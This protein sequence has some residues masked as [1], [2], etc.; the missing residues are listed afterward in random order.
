MAEERY[1]KFF[2]ELETYERSGVSMRLNDHPASPMQIVTAHMVRED[3]S[4]M[5]DYVW[6]EKG[7]V[8]EL[9]FHNIYT[10]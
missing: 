6:D 3:Q 5:R 4:Y 7:Q 9:T 2:A 1:K 8:R 10:S